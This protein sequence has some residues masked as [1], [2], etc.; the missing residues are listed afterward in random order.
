MF[1]T[2]GTVPVSLNTRTMRTVSAAIA[3][4]PDRWMHRYGA[5][6]TS[7]GAWASAVLSI[8]GRPAGGSSQ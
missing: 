3:S 7:P 2:F 6:R 8:A 4:W 1:T 5:F